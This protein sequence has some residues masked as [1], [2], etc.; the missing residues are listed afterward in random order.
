MSLIQIINSQ[1]ECNVRVNLLG[2]K[3]SEE[4]LV[5][6]KENIFTSIKMFFFYVIKNISLLK[7]KLKHS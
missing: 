4:R 1:S 7:I 2:W 6:Y 5:D 3:K